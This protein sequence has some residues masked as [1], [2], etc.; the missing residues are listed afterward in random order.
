MKKLSFLLLS[1]LAVTMFSACNDNNDEPVNKQ[2]IAASFNCRAYDGNEVVFSQN[3]GKVELN[4]TDMT[5]QI[6]ANYKDTDG[7]SHA[8]TT[9]VMGLEHRSGY[10]Y[11]FHELTD[12]G[13]PSGYIDLSTGMMWLTFTP[14]LGSTAYYCTSHLVYNNTIAYYYSTTYITNPD[15]GFNYNHEKSAYLFVP[16]AKGETCTMVIFNFIPNTA[17]SIE[18]SEIQYDGLQMTVTPDGYTITASEVEP[19]NYKGTYIIT[20]LNITLTHQARNINGTFE[21]NDLEFKVMGNLV[22]GN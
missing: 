19:T 11:S 9:G 21:C 4:Y 10:L 16:N 12:L 20:D 18:V 8:L 22:P 14:E 17:G 15:N 3:T 1:L 5:I 7:T 6:T 13:S 2:T